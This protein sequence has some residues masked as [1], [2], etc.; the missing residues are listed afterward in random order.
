MS[1]ALGDAFNR[2][3]LDAFVTNISERGYLFQN[4]TQVGTR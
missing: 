4:N 2:G 1:V 3:R